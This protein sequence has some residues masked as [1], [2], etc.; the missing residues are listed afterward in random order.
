MAPVSVSE[1]LGSGADALRLLAEWA[2]GVGRRLRA[3]APA[4]AIGTHAESARSRATV[5]DLRFSLLPRPEPWR[6]PGEPEALSRGYSRDHLLLVPRDPWSLLIAWEVTEATVAAARPSG[7]AALVL[8]VQE[9]APGTGLIEIDGAPATGW[10][11][12]RVPASGALYHAQ[13]GLR[14]ADGTFE[15]LVSSAPVHVP[16][17]HAS[18]D[19]SVR[20]HTLRLP[21]AGPASGRGRQAAPPAAAQRPE[22]RDG[23]APR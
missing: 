3:L 7:A 9:I 15:P 10:R 13:A 14:A 4:P 16:A 6:C 12:V 5:D 11:L 8:R 18:S 19:A 2:S 23:H 17:A 20:W 21:A 1:A 22:P